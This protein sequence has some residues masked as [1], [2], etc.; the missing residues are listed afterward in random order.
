M[1]VDDVPEW[2]RKLQGQLKAAF[3]PAADRER[4]YEQERMIDRVRVR[5]EDS[6]EVAAW[7]EELGELHAAH[8]PKI[9]NPK[10]EPDNS[11]RMAI[12]AMQFEER[13]NRIRSLIEVLD[14]H[15]G[16][17]PKSISHE[18]DERF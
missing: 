17:P 1:S 9:E 2:K 18:K 14:R 13:E 8:V 6:K 12:R 5:D 4:A 15:D 7:R 16:W 3:R 10:L 11:S